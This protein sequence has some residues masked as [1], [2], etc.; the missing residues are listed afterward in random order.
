MKKLTLFAL[1]AVLIQFMSIE[2]FSQWIEW[3]KRKLRSYETRGLAV[4]QSSDGNLIISGTMY[5]GGYIYKS[6]QNGDSIWT[7]LNAWGYSLIEDDSGNI[8]SVMEENYYKVSSNGA[9][10]WSKSLSDSL[11]SGIYS[12]TIA[13]TIDN[14]FIIAGGAVYGG[15]HSGYIIKYDLNGNKIWSNALYAPN[16]NYSIYNLSVQG[17][18]TFIAI[19]TAFAV[20]IERNFIAKISQNGQF[21]FSS[22]FGPNDD[23]LKTAH[24]V[25]R[26][27]DGGYLCFTSYRP[28]E[29]KL[30]ISKLDSSGNFLWS[31][32]HGDLYRSYS[33]TSG[34]SV[35]RDKYRNQ[36]IV[37]GSKPYF[38]SPIDTNFCSLASYDSLGNLLWDKLTYNDSFP[39]FIN[40]VTQNID[41]SFVI[42]GDAFV[43]YNSEVLDSPDY[44]YLLKTKK[45][46]PIGISNISSEIPNKFI[47]HQNYPNPFNPVT[48]IKFELPKSS[49]IEFNVY[50]ILGRKVYTEYINKSAGTYEI[51]FD[52]SGFA[53]GVY[54]Y[55]VKAGE[56]LDSKKMVI[57][58]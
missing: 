56:Y 47:L 53:S 11:Y 5:T 35:I 25:F 48:K 50:D 2:S 27:A 57:L 4:I 21:I 51:D 46:N 41:S 54:F 38:G 23:Y 39:S 34:Q 36:Y 15:N 20:N 43:N 37:A 55:S 31:R 49:N 14:K 18:G 6:N 30:I 13:K 10:I 19:G 16:K 58:K 45:I 17:D 33:I 52:A 28:G 44:L 42:C 40:G 26:L 7:C 9:L 8:Y 29:L 32:I 3:E 1:L 12:T 24:D 22:E